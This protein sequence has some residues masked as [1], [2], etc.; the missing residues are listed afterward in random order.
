M[1][2]RLK[3]TTIFFFAIVLW[4]SAQGFSTQP[5]HKLNDF[6]VIAYYSGDEKQINNYPVEK[7]THIIYSFVHL[8]GNK[9]EVDEKNGSKVIENLV[10]MKKRNSK[11]KVILSLGG[12]GG[13]QTCSEV[14]STKEGRDEFAESAKELLV[15]YHADGIDLD[16]EYPAIEGFPKHRFVPE[17]KQNFTALVQEM[18]KQFG[19]LYEISFAAGGFNTY[20]RNSIEWEKVIPY[21]DKVNLMSYDLTN[22]YSIITGHHTP[23]YSSKNQVESTD[24]AIRYFDSIQVPRSK[25]IIGAAFYARTWENVENKNHG[26]YQSGK[27]KDFVNYKD[28]DKYFSE[29]EGYSY[30][31][32]TLTQAPYRYSATKKIFATFDDPRSIALKTQYAIQ[33]KLGGIMFWEL[34][35]DIDN[36]GLLD[37]IDHQIQMQK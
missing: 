33:K 17:D 18:R 8:K 14:F 24:N 28:F 5:V 12:W 26:L 13:C 29:K 22:G 32:D 3:Q 21:I 10:S 36:N 23:L 15:K 34:S 1:E 6:S 2:P 31:W 30:Y 11:L 19:D 25:I 35:G 4:V 20:L 16:W 9:L 27:F 7:L 37:A